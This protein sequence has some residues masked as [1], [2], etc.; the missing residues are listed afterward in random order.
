MSV[1]KSQSCLL[2]VK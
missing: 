2:S 1:T